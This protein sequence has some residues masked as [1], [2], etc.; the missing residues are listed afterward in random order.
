MKP[1]ESDCE[2]EASRKTNADL[3]LNVLVRFIKQS[4]YS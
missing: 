3:L 4:E 2:S 1:F